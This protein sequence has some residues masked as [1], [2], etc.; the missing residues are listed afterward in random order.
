MLSRL[1]VTSLL[2]LLLALL[3]V[4]VAR[5]AMAQGS[6]DLTRD[7]TIQY[8]SKT[9]ASTEAFCKKLRSAC[10]SYVG[11][12]GTYGSH[13]QLDCRFTTDDGKPV[14]Q[15]NRIHAWCGGLEKNADGTWTN[16]GKVT[17]YT[18]QVLTKY[19]AKTAV[20]K[21]T[22]LSYKS[23]LNTQKRLGEPIVCSDKNAK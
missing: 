12:L 4:N 22:H 14:Q 19:F 6:L 21:G 20:I 13:H 3:Q 7:W 11:P 9:F 2:A 15:S 23:C 1:S 17:D 8:D 18:K 16:G 10:V 5:A